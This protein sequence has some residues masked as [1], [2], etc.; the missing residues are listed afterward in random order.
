MSRFKYGR[1][2]R[3][4]I[5]LIREAGAAFTVETDGKKRRGHMVMDG[6]ESGWRDDLLIET[7]TAT[8][9]CTIEVK[10]GDVLFFNQLRTRYRVTDVTPEQPNGVVLYWTVT[11]SR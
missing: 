1:I 5:Q 2:K 9:M 3:K 8:C 4:A 11:I 7:E 6:V 10:Q